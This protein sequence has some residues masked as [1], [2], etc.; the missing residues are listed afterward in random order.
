MKRPLCFIKMYEDKLIIKSNV[1][2]DGFSTLFWQKENSVNRYRC[3]TAKPYFSLE[4]FSEGYYV[5]WFENPKTKEQT[6]Q[7]SIYFK[8]ELSSYVVDRLWNTANITATAYT[9][10]LKENLI[11]AL[12][13]EPYRSLLNVIFNKYTE[14]IDLEI[15][16]EDIFYDLVL[17]QEAYENLQNSAA[18]SNSVSFARISVEP[19]PLLQTEEFITDVKVYQVSDNKKQLYGIYS[20]TGT[21]R[22]PLTVGLFEIQLLQ[23]SCLYGVLKHC[24]LSERCMTKLWD[25]VQNKNMDY[26]DDVENNLSSSLDFDAFSLEEITWYKEE[27]GLNSST[28]IL[29]RMQVTEE[30]YVHGVKLLVSGVSFAAV[31]NHLFYVSGRDIEFVNED[32]KNQFFPVTADSDNFTV[33]FDPLPALLDKGALLYIVDEQ[34]NI[35][36]R[37]TRCIFDEEENLA[38]YYEKVRQAE[39]ESYG[40]RFEAQVVSSYKDGWSYAQEMITRCLENQEVNV[41]NML[42]TLF[43]DV[44]NAPADIDKDLLS[45]EILKDYIVNKKYSLSFF[46]KN[47]LRWNP[48]TLTLTGEP[49]A[50]G[51]VLCIIAVFQGAQSCSSHYVHSFADKTVEV[52][53]NK[54]GRFAAFAISEY[55]YSFSGFFYTNNVTK[56]S[57]FYLM[58]K[59]EGT[60]D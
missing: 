41:D 50:T 39:I 6:E 23:G 2:Y 31:S 37:V 19:N 60:V 20:T 32:V 8:R 38:D 58:A 40:R 30:P 47:G 28:D 21:V 29:P 56:F 15:F 33:S 13:E 5:F 48:Y 7:I 42:Q 9:N 25:D 49:S 35:V 3:T 45:V 17:C 22:L 27:L 51:Y 12:D 53:L 10:K 54:Y 16:E 52:L 4:G 59:E 18:N 24:N 14:I 36:S 55:D 34:N 26:L 57:K 46:S 1:F 11:S 44:E 43:Y